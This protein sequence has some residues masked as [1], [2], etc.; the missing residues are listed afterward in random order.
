MR[1]KTVLACLV[2]AVF[3]LQI[4]DTVLAS[5][6]PLTQSQLNGTLGNENWYISNVNVE[7]TA[8]D[9]L[10]GVAQTAY[11]LNSD[12]PTVHEYPLGE[13]AILNPSFEE[14]N[15]RWRWLCLGIE[16]W[17]S[18]FEGW[19]VLMW[20]SRESHEGNYAAAI[21]NF[22]GGEAY[23][24]NRNS[25]VLVTPGRNY[26][27]SVWVKAYVFGP[28]IEV[29]G[30]V[31]A[32]KDTFAND[33]KLAQTEVLQQS[34]DWTK[35]GANFVTPSDVTQV[36]VRLRAKAVSPLT[37]VLFDEATLFAQPEAKLSF[38]VIENGAHTLH[39]YSTDRAGNQEAQKLAD[40][41]ID[42]LA[43][44]D[45]Q[46]F[47]FT[48][49]QQNH[50]YSASILVSD[51]TSGIEPASAQYH[52]YSDHQNWGWSEWLPVDS[53]LVAENGVP[54]QKGEIRPVKLT[55]PEV[56]F[57]DSATTYRFQ[58]KILDVAG[59]Q[60]ISPIQTIEGPW[61]R[62]KN[63]QVLSHNKISFSA[64]APAGQFNSNNLII[65]SQSINN[66]TSS[67]NLK[68]T[69][70]Q[71]DQLFNKTFEQILPNFDNLIVKAIPLPQNKLPTQ[72]G[73]YLYQGNFLIDSQTLSPSF[74]KN[75]LSA[76]I[77]IQGNL[78]IKKSFSLN[79]NSTVL[80]LVDGESEVEGAVSEINGFFITSGN[81]YSSID[82]K[83]DKQLTVKG[84]VLS[85]KNF[86]LTRDLGKGAQ[87]NSENPAEQFIFAPLLYLNRNL[88]SLLEGQD[89]KVEWLEVK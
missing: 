61:A 9:D 83:T 22:W 78:R 62:V 34:V 3:F 74:E 85:L 60:S 14:C 86:V 76:V 49:G 39:F 23:W 4:R 58:F 64:P 42:S 81:F 35:L 17:E 70:Y 24:H 46:N 84:G 87:G 59:S 68:V 37:A 6:P 69:N 25:A 38:S 63:A 15:L 16:S 51:A 11:F 40:F 43:P 33:I 30:E 1:V 73:I 55:T 31:W 19:G 72:S 45:W 41:K 13:N 57:G 12:P 82:G 88:A 5:N 27:F 26:N 29:G 20:R 52:F 53:I 56:N 66:F 54:A 47:V 67:A 36:Y 77:I 48:P 18:Y 10:E 89:R 50:T 71:D 28:N 65:S 2:S 8:T 44:Q 75:V 80:F 32:K 79:Q 21:G 7:L